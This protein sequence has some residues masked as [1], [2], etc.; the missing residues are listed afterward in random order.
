MAAGEHLNMSQFGEIKG[1]SD[2]TRSTKD[3]TFARQQTT[4][5]LR[6]K[7]GET[8]AP[9][10]S[11]TSSSSTATSQRVLDAWRKRRAG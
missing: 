4:Q 11:D 6:E 9:P 1:L 10:T 2:F 7:K 5:K 8:V 3:K